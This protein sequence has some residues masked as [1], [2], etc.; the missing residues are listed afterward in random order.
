MDKMEKR[1]ETFLIFAIVLLKTN[2][3]NKPTQK[4]T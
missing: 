4:N 1:I 3:T 2:Q